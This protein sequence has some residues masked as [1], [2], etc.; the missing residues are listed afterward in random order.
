MACPLFAEEF[1]GI[2]ASERFRTEYEE[3]FMKNGVKIK[4]VR[5]VK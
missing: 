4:Y 3:K 2:N 1:D 5:L